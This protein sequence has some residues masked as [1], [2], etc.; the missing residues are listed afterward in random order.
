MKGL[1][2]YQ[3][4]TDF[5]AY[6][7]AESEEEI[8]NALADITAGQI[9]SKASGYCQFLAELEGFADTCKAE[10]DRIA[11]VAKVAKNKADRIKEHMKECLINAD[12]SKLS[13][14]TF[15]VSVQN[16]PPSL[17]MIDE[18]Q[19]PCEYMVVI[20]ESYQIDKSAVKEALKN[21]KE[22]SGWELTVG[23]TLRIR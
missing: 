16:S 10:A 15:T 20:P 13:A 18:G 12:I 14:G 1:S 6:M 8:A 2:L 23:K 22:V 17:H 4:T 7:N 3:L 5:D 9:E 19:T 11:K 21:G